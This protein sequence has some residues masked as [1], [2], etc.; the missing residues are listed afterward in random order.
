MPAPAGRDEGRI[1]M[2]ALVA[3][4]LHMPAET[5][6]SLTGRIGMTMPMKK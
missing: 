1:A 4:E 2:T 6:W 5:S 3:K